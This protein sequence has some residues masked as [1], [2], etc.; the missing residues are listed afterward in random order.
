MALHRQFG[1]SHSLEH[2]A[3]ESDL[4]KIQSVPGKESSCFSSTFWVILARLTSS[5]RG[6]SFSV[7][8]NPPP[9]LLLG[10]SAGTTYSSHHHQ[11]P[12]PV[13]N[14]RYGVRK[15]QGPRAAHLACSVPRWEDHRGG[16]RGYLSVYWGI[17]VI[18]LKLHMTWQRLSR[19]DSE[20]SAHHYRHASN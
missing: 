8:L 2:R 14:V 16:L 6:E 13:D 17:G 1:P 9:A 5:R 20:P 7:R 4:P 18:I 12:P 10:G 11:K 15:A 3:D 19:A